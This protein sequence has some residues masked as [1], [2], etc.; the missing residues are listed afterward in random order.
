M[1]GCGLLPVPACLL[2]CQ[3]HTCQEE[4]DAAEALLDFGLEGELFL[5]EL[6]L[7]EVLLF[8]SGA[9]PL[10]PPAAAAPPTAPPDAAMVRLPSAIT[11][12]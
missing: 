8:A 5:A 3:V 11:S 12:M 6:H 7:D 1:P 10:P 9:T 4:E 2:L